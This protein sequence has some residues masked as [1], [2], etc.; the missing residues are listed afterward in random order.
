MALLF[1]SL[2][3]EV[4]GNH[5]LLAVFNV[6]LQLGFL[7]LTDLLAV[8]AAGMETAAG[9]NID[10]GGNIAFQQDALLLVVDI[11][12]GDSGQQSLG[13]LFVH[14]FLGNAFF[15]L[16]KLKGIKKLG[17]HLFS[18]VLRGFPL[19]LSY[20]LFVIGCIHV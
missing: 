15:F 6:G 9:G 16:E 12:H 3:G 10:G 4:A 1:E 7:F 17:I 20:D 5:M 14:V 8:L 13:D 19:F 2:V 18:F 11:G